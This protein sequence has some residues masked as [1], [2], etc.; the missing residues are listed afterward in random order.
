LVKK[1]WK[2]VEYLRSEFKRIGFDTGHTESAIIPV[3]LGNED[4]AKDF[5]KKLYELN[6][7][8]TPI[9]FPMV[10]K[11]KAR[12]R[13]IPSA[14]HSKEDLDLGIKAFEKVGK[15]LGAI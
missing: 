15:E 11:G 6:V 2:N 8:A 1:L 3:M 10:A 12:I 13:V 4:I 9:V 5:S 14:S 7:F